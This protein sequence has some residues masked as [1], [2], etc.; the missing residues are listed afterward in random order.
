MPLLILLVA[1]GESEPAFEPL[2]HEDRLSA[3]LEFTD[4]IGDDVAFAGE[5]GLDVR[6]ALE[7]ELHGREHLVEACDAAVEADVALQLWP[8][9][10]QDEGYWP[11]QGNVEPFIDWVHTLV[12]WAREDCRSL[13]G[14]A[15]DLEMPYERA[16][17]LQ[18]QFS[19]E[20][21]SL[22][23]LVDFFREGIDREGHE[24]ARALFQAE[25]DRLHGLGLQATLST[26]P[27][28]A[29]DTLD[30]DDTIALALWTPVER[31]G[32]DEMSVQVY[33]SLFDELFSGALDD[34]ETT[35]TSGLITS[36][37]GTALDAWGDRAA[38]DLGSTG[39]GISLTE[40]LASAAELQADLA[41]ALAAGIPLERVQIYS[42][43]G[44][45]DRDDAADW[46]ATPT[47]VAAAVDDATLELRDLIAALDLIEE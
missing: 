26:L 28:L 34:P 16:M 24:A 21:G 35:F 18:D 46:V 19:A 4:T 44:L 17:E 1:C 2:R 27:M 42:L 45:R 40:P 15:F 33:R 23:D 39:T 6:V 30:G 14:V 3:W 22:V 47:P 32:W 12:D 29:D 10:P 38:L 9:L 25:V 20:D 36:Y 43:E 11:N 37:A 7:R 8:L 5:L 41:A 31:I 13:D